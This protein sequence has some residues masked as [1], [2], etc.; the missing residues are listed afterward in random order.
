MSQ[1]LHDRVNE[2]LTEAETTSGSMLSDED[3]D[4][5]SSRTDLLE[6]AERANELLESADPDELLAAVGLDALPDGSE[7]NSIPEAIAKGDPERVEGL[8]RLL[9]LANLADGDGDGAG[10]DA[11]EDAVG[12]IQQS[13]GAGEAA[14]ESESTDED[15]DPS[16]G[17]EGDG[18]DETES[19]T[20]ADESESE[21]EDETESEDGGVREAVE[22][23]AEG[24]G[25]VLE[26]DE[27]ADE[28]AAD[29][30]SAAAPDDGGE[31]AAEAEAAD[32]TSG[33]IGDRLRSAVESTFTNAS[34]D[35]EGFRQRLQEASASAVA[36]EEDEPEEGEEEE[37]AADADADK[38]ED[39]DEGLLGSG[40]GS[41][42][43][44]GTPGGATRHSTVAPPPSQRAD[45]RGTAR[46]STMPDRH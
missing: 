13:I 33:D 27:A 12:R 2:I 18:E 38:R 9:H 32:E 36:G 20:D 46:H 17:E 29:D 44:R 30:A 22:S 1:D 31:D 16:E 43:D 7:P 11:I 37:E 42:Q 45:M 4:G 35:L 28:T 41:D 26:S 24:V 40:L 34:D 8:Q 25:D 19:E 21:G 5:E 39:E 6:S 10:G 3:G 14:D 23:V 15:E